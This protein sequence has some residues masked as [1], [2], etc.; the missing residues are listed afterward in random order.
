M[1]LADHGREVD[2]VEVVI[3][4][5]GDY[6]RRQGLACAGLVAGES[7]HAKPAATG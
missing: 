2:S 6:P 1:Y 3:Q 7:D 5:G 4:L